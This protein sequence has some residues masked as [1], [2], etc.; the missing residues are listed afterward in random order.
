MYSV[1]INRAESSQ[2][3]AQGTNSVAQAMIHK[4]VEKKCSCEPN[5]VVQRE[6]CGHT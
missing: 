3:I 2:S 5:V 6:K 1:S 4:N